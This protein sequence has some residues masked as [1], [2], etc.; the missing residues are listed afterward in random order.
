MKG[1]AAIAI[2][3][4]LAGPSGPA[5]A[6]RD[7][8]KDHPFYIAAVTVGTFGGVGNS[9]AALVY[10]IQGRSFH[11]AW[12]GSTLVS[13]AIC[14]TMAGSLIVEAIDDPGPFTIPGI[15]GYLIISLWPTAWLLRSAL[16]EVPL[17]A[18]FDSEV[19]P[20]ETEDPVDALRP[21][22]AELPATTVFSLV[23]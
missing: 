6:A 3:I 14:A 5:E 17:G 19:A 12:I 22:P 15:I 10:A 16:S 1:A 11:P 2:L 8:V 20:A 23:F 21:P 18:R 4:A 13:S 7:P 9:V